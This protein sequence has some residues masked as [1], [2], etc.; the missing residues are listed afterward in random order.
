M[1]PQ[2]QLVQIIRCLEEDLG[3]ICRRTAQLSTGQ[4]AN[5][6]NPE[7]IN[8]PLNFEGYS[9]APHQ[10][11]DASI[12]LDPDLLAF[13]YL[14]H[15]VSYLSW[16]SR[17]YPISPMTIYSTFSNS[18]SFTIWNMSYCIREQLFPTTAY[19]FLIVLSPCLSSCQHHG[20][21]FTCIF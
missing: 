12:G 18:I 16:Y 8:S 4:I 10:T 13:Q 20:Y 5:A 9:P 6:Q 17:P 7:Q 3:K 15:K 11:T 14:F 21:C 19:C 1:R 2:K